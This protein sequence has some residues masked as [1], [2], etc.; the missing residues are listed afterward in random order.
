MQIRYT[1]TGVRILSRS[2]A[3]QAFGLN[4]Y[5]CP[6]DRLCRAA[7]G[8]FRQLQET[9][10]WRRSLGPKAAAP[11]ARG[12]GTEGCDEVHRKWAAFRSSARAQRDF[13]QGR[14]VQA[15]GGGEWTYA[16]WNG[17]PPRFD[18]PIGAHW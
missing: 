12:M 6:P 3:D 14:W 15:E 10:E 9:K 1:L 4:P 17:K 18:D 11:K 5:K 16:K 13:T 7:V 2:S 8:H